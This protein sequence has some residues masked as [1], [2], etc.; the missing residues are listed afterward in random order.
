M[1]LPKRFKVVEKRLGREKAAGLVYEDDHDTLHIDP[2]LKSEDRLEILLHEAI[3][4]LDPAASEM[5]VRAWS[6]RL[7]AMLWRDRWRRVEK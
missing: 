2:T 3:H 1:K 6:R 4:L 5:K 7:S